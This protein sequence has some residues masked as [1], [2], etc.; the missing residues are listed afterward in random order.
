MS[1]SLWNSGRSQFYPALGAV[2]GYKVVYPRPPQS[3]QAPMMAASSRLRVLVL[4]C[5]GITNPDCEAGLDDVAAAM[6]VPAEVR[7]NV[8]GPRFAC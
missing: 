4:D 8:A 3:A 5:G 7:D 6:G 2:R 1:I